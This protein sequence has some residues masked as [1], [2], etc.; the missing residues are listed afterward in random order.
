[1]VALFGLCIAGIIVSHAFAP[2]S[3][4]A[5][6]SLVS[7]ATGFIFGFSALKQQKTKESD[8]G[9]TDEEKK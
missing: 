2:T 4:A 7:T 5:V 3:A 1:M 9:N 6:V 8:G